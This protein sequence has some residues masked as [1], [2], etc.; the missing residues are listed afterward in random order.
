MRKKITV[1]TS[2]A[3]IFVL[4]IVGVFSINYSNSGNNQLVRN[5]VLSSEEIDYDAFFNEF[6]DS[7][8]NVNES[9]NEVTFVG[10]KSYDKSMFDEVDFVSI[11][12]DD[13]EIS[14]EYSFYYSADENKYL[15]SIIADVEDG[16]I[17][18]N[19][20]GTAFI[21][22]NN[23]VDIAFSTD[24]GVILLSDL[25]E[26]AV[27]EKCGWFSKALKKVA[28][29][30]AV[31][32]VVAVVAAVVVVAAPA[33]VAAA[34]ATTAVVSAGGAAALTGASAATAIAAASAAGTAAMATTAF[35]LATTTAFVA[36]S[37]AVTAYIAS[38]TFDSLEE[39]VEAAVMELTK[40][41][42]FSGEIL[43]RADLTGNVYKTLTPRPVD[44]SGLSFFNN[45]TYMFGA[46]TITKGV[47]ITTVDLI[48][49]TGTL[50]ANK[51]G[52]YHYSITPLNGDMTD[53]ISTYASAKTNPHTYTKT[54]KEVCFYVPGI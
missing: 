6:D 36:S 37:V 20:E 15:L 45:K 9:K 43:Y 46:L 29:V 27:L 18:D 42:E 47:Y 52:I 49:G 54:L 30:A 12:P 22:D 4:A 5:V 14:I 8:L 25:E 34:T 1:L 3:L 24:D 35:A 28:K 32:A 7:T 2:L 53:W 21:A 40:L 16:V 19:W 48:E 31:V 26:S 11:S 17:V 38:K 50:N 44:V 41:K 23:E 33:V 39:K 51:D 13:E 10:V